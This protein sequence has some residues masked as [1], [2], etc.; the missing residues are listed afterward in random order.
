MPDI[1]LPECALRG[2]GRQ[3]LGMIANFISFYVVGIPAGYVMAFLLN[4]QLLGVWF[5]LGICDALSAA[6]FTGALAFTN[7]TKAM[8]DITDEEAR[9]A[10]AAAG[11]KPDEE[12][13]LTP[14]LPKSPNTAFY[15]S[16]S[17]AHAP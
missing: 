12:S 17:P 14:P 10:A 8:Q 7:W 11:G 1:Q 16:T 3:K 13:G 5:G 2:I 4:Q 6:V 15:G 9:N